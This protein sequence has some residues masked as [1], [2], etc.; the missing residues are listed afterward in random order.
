MMVI[1]SLSHKARIG[2]ALIALLLLS[3]PASLPEYGMAKGQGGAGRATTKP[4][5]PPGG[6][7][8]AP[9][10]SAR[11]TTT[12]FEVF[13]KEYDDIFL[14]EQQAYLADLYAGKPRRE[15]EAPPEPPD[16]SRQVYLCSRRARTLSYYERRQFQET[17]R[18]KVALSDDPV[19]KNFLLI[20]KETCPLYIKLINAPL[21][22]RDCLNNSQPINDNDNLFSQMWFR[23]YLAES[24]RTGRK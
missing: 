4:G 20:T 19:C 9:V 17:L 8:P 2:A 14:K 15:P 11:R 3:L 6:K 18:V 24:R 23:D 13:K 21:Y 16:R 10:K 5:T 7:K 22:V 12:L 1:R